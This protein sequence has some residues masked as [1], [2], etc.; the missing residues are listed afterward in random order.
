MQPQARFYRLI[1]VALIASL[2][3]GACGGGTSGKTWFN[4]PS[5]GINIQPNGTATVLGYNAGAIV[6]AALIQQ[7]Q[8]A[9]IQ[10]LEVRIG[11]NGVFV[12]A[13]GSNL[14]YLSWDADGVTTLQN[15]LPR[16]LPTL[17]VPNGNLIASLL[18]WLRT[19][20]LGVAINLPGANNV[21]R[22]SGETKFTPET[23]ATTI[24][25]IKL[26]GVS[27]DEG[28]TLYINNIPGDRFGLTGSLLDSNTLNLL[29]T[30]G[31]E[32]LQI[33]THPNGISLRMNDQPLP[34]LA[35]DSQ[36]LANAKSLIG[37]L[38]PDQ[39]AT[40]ETA[41]GALQ[42]AAVDATV[43][44][45][46]P[47]EGEIQLGSVP[48]RLNTD[49]TLSAFGAPVP[50]V[51]LPADVIQKLEQ[52]GVQTLNVDVNE[53][54]VFLAANGQTLPTITWTPESLDML[55]NVVA[56]LTGMDPGMVGGVLEIIRESGGIKANIGVG[57]NEPT[58]AEIDTT[59]ESASGEGAPVLRL[60][61][62]VTNG[63]IE[64]IEGLGSL[65]DLGV[66][67]VALPPNV[68]QILDQ[69]GA[70]ELTINTGDGKV[71]VQLDG[72]T[73]LTLNW[74]QPSILA[75]LQLAG[76]F[77]AGTPLEDPNVLKLVQEQIVPMLP[78]ADVDVTLH[79]N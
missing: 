9:N 36:S 3:L 10:K 60:N 40:I 44:F 22:W 24:G 51:T 25:P 17:G 20:G 19:I 53:N 57:D 8:A 68:M 26:S 66:G 50:G 34:G 32:K 16:L 30:L 78:G 7:L 54:G 2:V 41:L 4:L 21:A 5:I 58:E 79:L 12:Y 71:D 74:D 14:P 77:L 18:P 47:T 67:P 72:A 31:L 76:P 15:V 27:F 6:P 59:L 35:Y 70:N 11:Y 64:S 39:A 42:G 48:V 13:N 29:T 75:A 69:V 73:A 28:G 37:A 33:S 62:N 1:V 56:P 45:T 46:G 65:S 49:G 38:A 23:P 43:S 52:A 55:G 63:S 61:A